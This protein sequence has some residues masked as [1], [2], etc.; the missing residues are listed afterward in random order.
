MEKTHGFSKRKDK[1]IKNKSILESKNSRGKA[2]RDKGLQYACKGSQDTVCIGGTKIMPYCGFGIESIPCIIGDTGASLFSYL[3]EIF[4]T[5]ALFLVV[6]VAM[7]LAF[8]FF[9]RK[10]VVQ[11]AKVL[12]FREALIIF[13]VLAIIAGITLVAFAPVSGG[14]TAI[15]GV[16]SGLVGVL[17]AMVGLKLK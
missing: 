7:I 16:F 9:A 11:L 13:G 14:T 6:F 5:Y 3:M 4:I 8:L 17:S 1:T 12:P 15:V 10:Q 2:G